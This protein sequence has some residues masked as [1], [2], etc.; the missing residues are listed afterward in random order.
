M[1]QMQRHVKL[2][3]VGERGRGKD[4]LSL[5]IPNL[6]RF[7]VLFSLLS[8]GSSDR[9]IDDRTMIEARWGRRI[10]GRW[11]MYVGATV[12]KLSCKSNSCFARQRGKKAHEFQKLK[13]NNNF[14]LPITFRVR[15]DEIVYWERDLKKFCISSFRSITLGL[16]QSIANIL[17]TIKGLQVFNKTKDVR[18][19]Q[20]WR[21]N[22]ISK[23]RARLR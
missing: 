12:S 18:G 19:R 11:S 22:S 7:L 4:L 20:D 23:E 21:A 15:Y 17:A 5:F 10:I 2:Y 13:N 3:Y 8:Q 6:D 16:P 1:Q 9:S 14:L